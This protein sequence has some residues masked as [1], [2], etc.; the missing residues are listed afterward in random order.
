MTKRAEHVEENIKNTKITDLSK[1]AECS[2]DSTNDSRENSI[3]YLC[4]R[5]INLDEIKPSTLSEKT[6]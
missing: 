1:M 3:P 5:E 6:L 4:V 2:M